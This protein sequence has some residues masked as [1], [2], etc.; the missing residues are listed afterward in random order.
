[1]LVSRSIN[2]FSYRSLNPHNVVLL[3]CR[4]KSSRQWLA[5]QKKDQ[6]TRQAKSDDYRSRAAYK[7]KEIDQSYK[8]FR[9]GQTVVDLGFAPGSWSQVAVER[10]RP[11]GRVIGLDLIAA[12]PPQGVSSLQGNFLDPAIQEE[13]KAMLASPDRG[14]FGASA[15]D[16]LEMDVDKAHADVVLSDMCGIWPQTSGFWINSINT[17]Y[18]LANVSGNAVRDHGRS[19]VS[20]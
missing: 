2:I 15:S 12:T 16:P 11:N 5:R 4:F 7:L 10:T 3:H 8:I 1:M 18:S 9:P 19:M 17:S 20:I 14:R 6:F 13:L